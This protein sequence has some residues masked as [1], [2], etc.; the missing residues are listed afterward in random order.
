MTNKQDNYYN[1][2]AHV[3]LGLMVKKRK[4]KKEKE[5]KLAYYLAS[6]SMGN[7]CY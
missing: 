7:Q 2:L 1:P 6:D 4:K 3:H 5:Q